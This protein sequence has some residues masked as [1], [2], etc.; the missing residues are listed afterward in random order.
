MIKIAHESPKS[1]FNTV[2]KFTDYD[3]A[4]VHLFE[5]DKEYLQQFREA[6]NAGR[7]IILDNSIFELEEAFD[8]DKFDGWVND[9]KPTWYIVPDVLEDG[10]ETIAKMEDWNNKGLG[11]PGSGKIGVVQGKTYDEIVDCYNFMNNEGLADMIAISFDYSYYEDTVPHTNKYV[12]W[13]LGRVKLLGDLLKDGV[14][15]KHKKHHLLGCG[16][17]QEFAF[18]KHSDYD[19]IY[20]LDTS[21]PVVHGIKGITYND[22]GLWNKESQKLFEMINQDVSEKQISTILNNIQKFR[23]HTNGTNALD[24][25]F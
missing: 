22:Q 7:E 19:W 18:Y 10:Y 20:S 8:A 6:R 16:L 3:Y 25:I 9:L 23:W 11:Y 4:L 24:S 2:Q 21:N 15:N 17:P 5:E 14:I 12:S 13:M 1:I